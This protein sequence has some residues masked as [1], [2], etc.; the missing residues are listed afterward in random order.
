MATNNEKLNEL[1][2]Q[3]LSISV[4]E[5]TDSTSSENTSAW[6]SFNGLLLVAEIEELF[7]VQFSIDEIYAISCV[8]DIR[9]LLHRHGVEC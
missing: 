5:I 2:S 9:E 7:S 4:G 3:V 6:D 1:L 8:K